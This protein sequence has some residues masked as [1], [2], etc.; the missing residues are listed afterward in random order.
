MFSE[1]GSDGIRIS[2]ILKGRYKHD[3]NEVSKRASC[4]SLKEERGGGV[5]RRGWA[6]DLR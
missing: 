6:A 1:N 3:G 2:D 5:G 4:V